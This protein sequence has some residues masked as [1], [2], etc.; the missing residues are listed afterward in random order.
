MTINR[1]PLDL[2]TS[3]A[4]ESR[5]AGAEFAQCLAAGDIV[6]LDGDL[7]AG[8]TTFTQ[9]IARGLGIE[10]IIQSPTFTIVAEYP[11]G[12][13]GL[14]LVH[15][16]LY[17]LGSEEAVESIGLHDLLQRE[18]SVMLVEWPDRA[19][20]WWTGSRWVVEIEHLGGDERHIGATFHAN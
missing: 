15:I 3:S 8:K 10:A 6:L 18:Q 7:G 14:E 11:A 4:E 13:A 2:V 19:S 16:D 1:A 20:D 5:S 9:G 12:S 17:R